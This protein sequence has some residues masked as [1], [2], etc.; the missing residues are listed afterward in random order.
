M[1]ALDHTMGD[2]TGV[3]GETLFFFAFGLLG[4]G[5]ASAEFI[6]AIAAM[7]PA[8]EPAGGHGVFRAFFHG[9]MAGG[10][11]KFCI[12]GHF[13]HLIFSLGF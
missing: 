11:G 6:H 3:P 13:N 5:Y 12:F 7:Y 10:A 9:N 2:W 1:T 8:A 4:T